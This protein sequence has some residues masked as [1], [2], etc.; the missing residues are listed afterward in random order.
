[1]GIITKTGTILKIQLL[2]GSP[3]KNYFESGERLFLKTILSKIEDKPSLE[4]AITSEEK[5]LL[6]KIFDKYDKYLR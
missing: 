5:E 2:Q 6:E 3:A 1:M 4:L